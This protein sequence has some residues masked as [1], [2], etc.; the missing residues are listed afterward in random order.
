MIWDLKNDGTFAVLYRFQT[1]KKFYFAGEKKINPE[2]T[3]AWKS[4]VNYTHLKDRNSTAWLYEKNLAR[5]RK[6]FAQLNT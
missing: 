5:T 4:S 3:A 6:L 1:K 2:M